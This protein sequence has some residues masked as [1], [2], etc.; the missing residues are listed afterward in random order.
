[1]KKYK[2]Q[3]SLISKSLKIKYGLLI[4]PLNDEV[5]T[6]VKLTE[7]LINNGHD[8]EEAGKISAQKIFKSF[9]FHEYAESQADSIETLLLKIKEK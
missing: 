5:N 8:S 9:G 3:F 1:M 4:S 2:S 7:E 6:W